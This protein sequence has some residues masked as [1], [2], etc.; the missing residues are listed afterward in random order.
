METAMLRTLQIANLRSGNSENSG[1]HGKKQRRTPVVF[2][3]LS[4]LVE[5]SRGKPA[6]GLAPGVGFC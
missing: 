4:E 6:G 2:Q 3:P 5:A 1:L